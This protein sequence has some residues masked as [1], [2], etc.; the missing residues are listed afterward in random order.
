MHL[1]AEGLKVRRNNNYNNSENEEEYV[2]INLA[3]L[4]DTVNELA[5]GEVVTSKDYIAEEARRV[6]DVVHENMT[7][8]S[9]VFAALTDCHYNQND[10]TQAAIKHTAEALYEI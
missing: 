8:D 4:Y 2:T 3:N 7:A 10:N 1:T 6:A 9:F 5:G